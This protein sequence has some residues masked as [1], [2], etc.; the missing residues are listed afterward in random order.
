[1]SWISSIHAQ[2]L[3]MGGVDGFIG[4]GRLHQGIEGL[5]EGFYSVNLF[6]AIW[7]AGDV[8]VIWNP[9]YNTDRAGPIFLPGLKAHAEF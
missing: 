4:D 3:A 5:V 6:K 2:Y 8:Q 9:G 1:M 7:L